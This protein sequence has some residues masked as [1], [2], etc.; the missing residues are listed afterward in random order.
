MLRAVLLVRLQTTFCYFLS[1]G[2]LV[3]KHAMSLP[4]AVA[5]LESLIHI[6]ESTVALRTG[7]P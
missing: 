7:F 2:C 1:E 3:T 4:R 5:D 6:S